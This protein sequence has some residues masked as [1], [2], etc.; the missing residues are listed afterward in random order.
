MW[1]NL[2]EGFLNVVADVVGREL[3]EALL[4]RNPAQSHG[5]QPAARLNVSIIDAKKLSTDWM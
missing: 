5:K 3:R 4:S 2:A 1:I